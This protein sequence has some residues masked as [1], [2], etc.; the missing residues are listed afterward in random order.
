MT[1]MVRRYCCPA[2][3]S[4]GVEPH[5]KIPYTQLASPVMVGGARVRS[6]PLL[7]P[8]APVFE[9][10]RCASCGSIFR[11]PFSAS[12]K[13][14]QAAET[15]FAK[16]LIEREEWAGYVANYTRFVAPFLL[17][18]AS[19]LLEAC[20]GA[21]QML[22]VAAEARQWDALVGVD[23]CEPSVAALREEGRRRG[24]KLRTKVCDLDQAGCLE[25]QALGLPADFAILAEAL[26][27]VEFPKTVLE[28]IWGAMRGK[29][30]LYL[31][32]QSPEGRL[33][34]RPE[35][36][37]LFSRAAMDGLA[38]WLKAKVILSTLDAGRWKEVWEKP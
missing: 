13:A 12:D 4:S 30:R 33:P 37:I 24:L 3:G 16:K 2:C 35:E 18:Q 17:P 36:P 27:H 34:V 38:E 10:S 25:D 19:V 1:D 23:I 15:R 31:T 29:G 32:A 14:S 7:D 22:L 11:D 21:G 20:C 9:F 28:N 6:I 8:S 26:E 5:W